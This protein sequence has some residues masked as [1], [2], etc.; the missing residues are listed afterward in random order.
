MDEEIIGDESPQYKPHIQGED[1]SQAKL[2]GGSQNR[3]QYGRPPAPISHLEDDKESA[4]V[5]LQRLIRDF[6]H[7]AVGPGL[8][9]E[10]QSQALELVAASGGS[11]QALLRMDRRL[12]RLELWPPSTSDGAIG[13][14]PTLSVPL[15]LVERIV[16]GSSN[17]SGDMPEPSSQDMTEGVGSSRENSTLTIVQRSAADLRLVF[18]SAANRDK[19]YTCLRIFQMSVDQSVEGPPREDGDGDA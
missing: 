3:L 18:D 1:P 14:Q 10:A 6:A 15:Q 9:I 19:A 12:S 5:R 4:K 7:D 8:E 17:E 2:P 13:S 16:K 11:L